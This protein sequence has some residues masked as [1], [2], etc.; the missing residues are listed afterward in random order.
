VKKVTFCN[1]SAHR[2]YLQLEEMGQNTPEHHAL[3]V[4]TGSQ[5]LKT[6][7]AHSEGAHEVLLR[8]Y[9]SFLSKLQ[10]PESAT[11]VQGMRGFVR[12]LHDSSKASVAKSLESYLDSTMEMLKIHP[13]F[14]SEPDFDMVRRSLQSF[15]YGHGKDAVWSTIDT[16]QD[17]INSQRWQA[18]QFVTPE[19][20]DIP[21]LV[22][23]SPDDLDF[24]LKDSISALNL[25]ELFF[26]PYEKLQSILKAYHGINAALS[27]ALNRKAGSKK[28]PSADDILPTLIL[29]VLR[30]KPKAVVSN[31]AMIETFSP[32]EHLRGEAWYAYTNLYGAIQ[33]LLDLDL[34][35]DPENL[36]ISS[37][38]FRQG[39]ET[40]RAAAEGTFSKRGVQA[41]REMQPLAQLE[42]LAIPVSAIRS[43][44]LAG[45]T[46][47]VHWAKQWYEEN[48][49]VMTV[50]GE[51]SGPGV[52]PDSLPPGFT[53]SYAFLTTRPDEVRVS[54]L[55]HLLAEYRMLVH[56]TEVLLAERSSRQ[57]V[58]R[59]RRFASEQKRLEE[60][61]LES[62][63]SLELKSN[64]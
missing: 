22:G 26:S 18:L 2:H 24:L 41:D 39:L 61:A 28:L 12:S 53:R 9:R 50:N 34:D 31:L 60:E 27:M 11:L 25:V 63:L 8:A 21:C 49:R 58:A 15:V 46:T 29:S 20:L 55:P 1:V 30:A 3:V 40:F 4:P 32:P 14:S 10:M 45:V 51:L 48:R 35:K 16:K 38:D 23:Q 13:A 62:E 47:N 57:S 7:L 56:T 6:E 42:D 54:D 17:E 43:A 64:K 52:L 19:H 37:Q 33:F 36:T 44:R 59:K 5:I